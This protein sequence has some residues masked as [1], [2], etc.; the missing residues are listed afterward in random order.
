[1]A[2]APR[3][4]TGSEAR[5]PLAEAVNASLKGTNEDDRAKAILLL[6]ICSRLSDPTRPAEK[7]P[8]TLAEAR[9]EVRQAGLELRAFCGSGP[10]TPLI[11]VLRQGSGAA[12]EDRYHLLA[13]SSRLR[14]SQELVQAISTV[15]SQPSVYPAHVQ[16]LLRQLVQ[17]NPALLPDMLQAGRGVVYVR[18]VESLIGDR[19]M[20]ALILA[21]ACL[22]AGLCA[23]QVATLEARHPEVRALTRVLIDQIRRQDWTALLATLKFE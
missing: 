7:L 3:A 19:D 14:S 16:V 13:R 12:A 17:Q 23:S 2:Q 5:S 10:T 11:E 18:L 4:A 6:G 21:D 1:M 9:D 20:S 15:L 8:I 22:D